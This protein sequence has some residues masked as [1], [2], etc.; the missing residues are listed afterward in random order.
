MAL[1]AVGPYQFEALG[2]SFNDRARKSE[3][4]WAKL[5]VSGGPDRLQ[6]IGARGRSDT[7]RGV[8]FSEFGGQDALDGL[9]RS[10]ETGVILP[11]VAFGAVPD[12]VFG[13]VVVEDV[14]QDESYHHSDGTPRRNAY[15]LK[16]TYYPG[17]PEYDTAQS[18]FIQTLFDAVLT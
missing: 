16:L 14:S 18:N 15:S 3:T 7:I 1:M 2:F 4:P 11:F 10:A 8:L 13:N 5:E 9:Q 17:Q 12:N 6:W